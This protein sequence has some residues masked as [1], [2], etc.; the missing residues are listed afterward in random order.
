MPKSTDD[1][2][3]QASV[4]IANQIINLANELLEQGVSSA[5]IAS[6]IRHA[7]ANFTAFDFF[8][9]NEPTKDPNVPV[10]EFISQ[11]EYYLSAHKP[12]EPQDRGIMQIIE[13]AKNELK[14]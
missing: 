6:G 7:A 3:S 13:Q 1:K 9:N 10:E 11:F 12:K 2:P 8:Q 4:Q 5:E 14:N